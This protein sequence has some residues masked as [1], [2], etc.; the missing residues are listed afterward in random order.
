[1]NFLSMFERRPFL[2][3]LL[4]PRLL[5]NGQ[6]LLDHAALPV[7]F[8]L[9][10]LFLLSQ[11]LFESSLMFETLFHR[12]VVGLLQPRRIFGLSRVEIFRLNWL[13]RARTDIRLGC[14]LNNG[15]LWLW[16]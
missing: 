10:G 9:S 1:M 5:A 12:R 13:R 7:Q 8:R 3:P 11:F 15:L 4:A 2:V 14:R 6:F 16:L